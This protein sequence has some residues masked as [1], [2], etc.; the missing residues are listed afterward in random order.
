MTSCSNTKMLIKFYCNRLNHNSRVIYFDFYSM[1]ARDKI[2]PLTGISS[3][4]IFVCIYVSVCMYVSGCM[5]ICMYVYV[6]VHERL[7]AYMCMYVH[8]YVCTYVRMY[9][10]MCV[11]T[12][13]T[14]FCIQGNTTSESEG[15]FVRVIHHLYS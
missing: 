2:F 7:R 15:R 13:E 12:V 6:W 8:T 3:T 1:C 11:G 10:R 4:S 5:H 9:V 14:R